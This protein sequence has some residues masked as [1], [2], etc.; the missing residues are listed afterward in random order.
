[1]DMKF[2]GVVFTGSGLLDVLKPAPAAIHIADIGHGLAAKVRF[3][4]H[5]RR[6]LPFYSVAWHSLFSEMIADQMGLPIKT[7]LQALLHDAP[8]YVMGDS[9]TPVKVLLSDFGPIESG[10][11]AA[12]AT[13]YGVPVEFAPEVHQ[14]DRLALD[15]ERDAI[16]VPGDWDP[17]PVV[18]DEWR[19][20]VDKWFAFWAANALK[21]RLDAHLFIARAKALISARRDELGVC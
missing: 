10:L 13:K 17:A 8:E 9:V 19:A 7:R 2:K 15:C 21:P 11:W 5:T 14:I 1:M 18:P 6:D 20:V 16:G 3:G 12:I 4:G